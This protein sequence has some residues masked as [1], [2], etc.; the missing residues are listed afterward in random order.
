MTHSSTRN[1]CT[2]RG[3]PP[4]AATWKY[5]PSTSPRRF[6]HCPGRGL[7]GGR[8]SAA[9]AGDKRGQVQ[10]GEGNWRGVGVSCS[11]L[12]HTNG[13]GTRNWEW[14]QVVPGQRTE[15]GGAVTLAAPGPP[16]PPSAVGFPGGG[17]GLAGP[18]PT[19]RAHVM[20][21]SAGAEGPGPP[22]VP[23]AATTAASETAAAG[24]AAAGIGGTLLK[25]NAGGGGGVAFGAC[26]WRARL[27]RV[28]LGSQPATL[29]MT[30]IGS[31]CTGG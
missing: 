7:G 23:P 4:S 16:G 27:R 6:T 9:N 29:G 28:G 12:A 3:T 11:V 13:V 15:S 31:F 14:V 10:W 26:L 18:A 8:P 5:H 1:G 20:R 22:A 30:I 19:A 25:N 24:T 21:V 17:G 2:R